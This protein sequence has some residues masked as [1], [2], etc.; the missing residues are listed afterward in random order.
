[1]QSQCSLE[2]NQQVQSHCG[3]V[4]VSQ[5]SVQRTAQEQNSA[6]QHTARRAL[7]KH[8][9]KVA[10]VSCPFFRTRCQRLIIMQCSL[11]L[12]GS[13]PSTRRMKTAVDWQFTVTPYNTQSYLLTLV[14]STAKVLIAACMR[15]KLVA[16]Q[17]NSTV[18]PWVRST[19]APCKPPRMS[20]G[21]FKVLF[22]KAVHRVCS[23]HHSFCFR[24]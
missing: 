11:Q 23:K 6:D 13:M 5:P 10:L 3:Q 17:T 19:G 7:H 4:A 21:I 18:N 20:V 8:K 14:S 15:S 24:W 12:E 22:P 16:F 1:M 2:T 9:Q